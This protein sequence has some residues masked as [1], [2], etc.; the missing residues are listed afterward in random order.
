MHRSM[1]PARCGTTADASI[2]ALQ[3]QYAEETGIAALKLRHNN[4]LGYHIDATSEAGRSLDGAAAQCALHPPANQCRLGALRA[5]PSWSSSTARSPAPAMRRWRG[6]WSCSRFRRA[7]GCGRGGNRAAAE[8][9][10]ALDVAS[11]LAD[12]AEETGA[13]AA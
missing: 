4:V 5:P 10:A 12:W 7:G 11:G 9:L 3:A 8:A 6:S 1:K 13:V 2:A